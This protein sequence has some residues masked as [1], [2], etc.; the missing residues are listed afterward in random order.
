MAT[1]ARS[2]LVHFLNH[3]VRPSSGNLLRH[4]DYLKDWSFY[5][6]ALFS[7]FDEADDEIFYAQPRFV[8][9]IDDHA[10]QTLTN[11]YQDYFPLHCPQTAVLDL[12]SSWIS[13]FPNRDYMKVVGLG[14]NEEELKANQQLT[15]YRVQNL[16][17]TPYL[18]YD[19]NTFDIITNTVSVDYLNKPWTVF[20]EMF[21]VLKP[22]EKCL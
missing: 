13:H 14:L 10:I 6:S 11:Y 21:R 19:D 5:D 2:K 9:H 22:N 18:P 17:T 20:D 7:R 3:T 15:E 1:E 8:T 4:A 12:C 16:N